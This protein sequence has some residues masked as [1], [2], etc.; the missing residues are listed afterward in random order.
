MY[1]DP[2]ND[3][4]LAEL[5]F[6]NPLNQGDHQLSLSPPGLFRNTGGYEKKRGFDAN[7]LHLFRPMLPPRSRYCV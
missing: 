3:K 5:L 6:P 2:G 7:A 4:V 1:G